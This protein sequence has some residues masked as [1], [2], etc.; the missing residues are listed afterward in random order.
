MILDCNKVK[1]FKHLFQ[2]QPRRVVLSNIQV[3][4]HLKTENENKTLNKFTKCQGMQEVIAHWP[5][6]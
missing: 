4:H 6:V 2:A 5:E 1:N 3:K